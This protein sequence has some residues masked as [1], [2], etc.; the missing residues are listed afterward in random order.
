MDFYAR[1]E[2]PDPLEGSVLSDPKYP[3]LGP[4]NAEVDGRLAQPGGQVRAGSTLNT[5]GQGVLHVVF[6]DLMEL[7]LNELTIVRVDELTCD[8]SNGLRVA[9]TV[10][11]GMAR[12][13][14][15]EHLNGSLRID[16]PGQYVKIPPGP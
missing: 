4:R 13:K 11:A 16:G 9:L 10:F 8:L 15:G 14:L 7:M 6:P 2:C 12:I 3:E 1:G 5:S